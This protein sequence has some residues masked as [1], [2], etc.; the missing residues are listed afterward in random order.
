MNI[1]DKTFLLTGASG[2]IGGILVK[3]L[4]ASQARVILVGRCGES[5]RRAADIS[6]GEV[7]T[8]DFTSADDVAAVITKAQNIDGIINCAGAICFAEA[9][10][11]DAATINKIVAVN[12]AA[13]MILTTGLLPM[14]LQ[15]PEAIIVNIDS[16]FGFIGHPGY[17]AY[18][19]TKFG[20][21]GFCE[22]LSRELADT[23]V[24]VVY[25]APRVVATGSNSESAV[26]MNKALGNN[27]DSPEFVADVVM[28]VIRKD[29]SHAPIRMPE[30][31]FIKLKGNYVLASPFYFCHN[32]GKSNRA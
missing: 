15:R 4:T 28:N 30:R 6:G 32:I 1:A 24:R 10:A 16:V 22:A 13:P 23:S 19:A 26:A 12:L 31:L 21:R 2:G 14:L 20:L 17:A 29:H 9:V 27:C 11:T 3:Y 25:V 18:C 5:L 7:I 8:A